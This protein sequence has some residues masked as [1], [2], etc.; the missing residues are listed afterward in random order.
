MTKPLGFLL[1]QKF[2]HNPFITLIGCLLSLRSTDV[3]TY[4]VCL[5]LFNLAKTPETLLALPQKKLEDILYSIGFYKKKAHTL[6]HVCKDILERFN[7]MVPNSYEALCSIKGIGPK[8]ANLVLGQGF[9]IPAICVDIHVHRI[10]NRLGLVNTK[11]PH[12]T[13]EA[14][15]EILPKSYWIEYNTLI[16]MW[17]QNIC[18][19]LSP[20]CSKCGI[21]SLCE[22]KGVTKHR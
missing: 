12:Q 14:L 1:T 18:T 19:P 10:S 17:G 6:K 13:E 20:F 4:P 15:K 5:E 11:T 9:G 16:V 8:T 21:Y 3:R 2:G 22:R 7:G